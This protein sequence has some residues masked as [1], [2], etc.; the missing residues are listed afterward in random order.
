[1]TANA[2][3]P[4][5][6]RTSHQV[7]PRSDKDEATN[8]N[9]QAFQCRADCANQRTT[10]LGFLFRELLV[11]GFSRDVQAEPFPEP[12]IGLDPVSWTRGYAA[13]LKSAVWFEYCS[14]NWAGL[15]WPIEACR[16]RRL[17]R[18]SIHAPTS[19]L[20][21]FRVGQTRR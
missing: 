5:F 9:I 10:G 16:R 21:R 14:S 12:V 8:D 17:Y 13:F 18:S 6:Q 4:G 2:P 1:M 11:E 7:K 15:I 19:S 3:K 20:A